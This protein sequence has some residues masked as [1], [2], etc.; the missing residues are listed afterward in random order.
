MVEQQDPMLE[1]AFRGAVTAH[2]LMRKESV[3][4]AQTIARDYFPAGVPVVA[5]SSQAAG[6]HSFQ[7]NART[8]IS[9]VRRTR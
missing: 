7:R 6:I 8:P 2:C 1:P 9:A 3:T 4:A 5:D